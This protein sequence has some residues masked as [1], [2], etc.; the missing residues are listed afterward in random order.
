[1][2]NVT[3]RGCYLYVRSRYSRQGGPFILS[4]QD[5]S[6]GHTQVVCHSTSRRVDI[7]KEARLYDGRQ[8]G[9]LQS[10]G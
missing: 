6:R 9:M 4:M 3:F 7:V 1:M 5:G 2:D 10:T 8:S